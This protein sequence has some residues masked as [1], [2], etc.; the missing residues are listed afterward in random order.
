MK[1]YGNMPRNSGISPIKQNNI[2]KKKGTS[3]ENVL[4]KFHLQFTLTIKHYNL[5]F[6]S[7]MTF[8]CSAGHF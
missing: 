7:I 5:D 6:N 1:A 2:L 8:K 3:V 4:I